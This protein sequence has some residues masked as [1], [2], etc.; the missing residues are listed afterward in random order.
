M[1][2]T[3]THALFIDKYSYILSKYYISVRKDSPPF[4]EAVI[5]SYINWIFTITY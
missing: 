3:V 5:E 1:D 4:A 2:M